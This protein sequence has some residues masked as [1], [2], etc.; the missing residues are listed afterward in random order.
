MGIEQT[1]P[2][3][4]HSSDVAYFMEMARAKGHTVP[5]ILRSILEAVVDDDREEERKQAVGTVQSLRLVSS[6]EGI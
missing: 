3:T 5:E 6:N 2:V 1:I 4:L